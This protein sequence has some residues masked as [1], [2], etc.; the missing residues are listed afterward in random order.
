MEIILILIV[1]ALKFLL[2]VAILYFP[3]V[4]GWANFFLDSTDGDILIPLG[5]ADSTYQPID[6]IA[7]WATYIAMVILAYKANWAIKKLILILF[8]FRSIG[9]TLFLLT[10]NELMLFFFPNFL[11]PLFLTTASIMA[12]QRVIKKRKDWQKHTFK[13]MSRHKYLI[14]ILVIVYKMQDEFFTHVSNTDRTEIISKLF[15]G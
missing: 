11:E 6:K 9:Q 15:G 10:G 8:L 5:L 13:V 7:D 12:Y 4:A 1:L 3:F 2:P 14:A